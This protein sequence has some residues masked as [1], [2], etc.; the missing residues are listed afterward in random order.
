MVECLNTPNIRG[1]VGTVSSKPII[2]SYDD[3]PI[4][5]TMVVEG[6]CLKDPHNFTRPLPDLPRKTLQN[7]FLF[8]G[9]SDINLNDVLM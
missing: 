8:P 5:V 2:S 1:K 4:M 7:V 6:S 3:R 9:F